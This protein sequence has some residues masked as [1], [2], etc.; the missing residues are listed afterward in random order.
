MDRGALG[1]TPGAGLQKGEGRSPD[2][3]G[4]NKAIFLQ[5]TAHLAGHCL[6][7]WSACLRPPSGANQGFSKAIS[8]SAHEQEAHG[9]PV[10]SKNQYHCLFP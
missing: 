9:A 6:R 8:Q 10:I 3:N 5:P 1:L 4:R 2:L 7:E